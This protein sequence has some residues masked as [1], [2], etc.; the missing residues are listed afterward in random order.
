M[1]STP[2][3]PTVPPPGQLFSLAGRTALV[4][5]GSSGIGAMICAGFVAAGARVLVAARSADSLDVAVQQLSR[6]GSCE[7]VV[8][9]V[10][11]AAGCRALASEVADRCDDGLDILV[12]NAGTTSF[13]PLEH[14]SED[15][16][17]DVLSLNVTS[18]QHLTAAL[19]PQLRMRAG[20][21]SPARVLVIGSTSGFELSGLPDAVYGA[22]KAA[23]HHLARH[24]AAELVGEHILVNV[25]APGLFP[26]RL[27]AFLDDPAVR[28]PVLSTIPMGRAGR[29][30]EVA[31]AALFLCSDA[32]T[33]V[34][35]QVVVVDGGRTGLGRAD[36]VAGL[37]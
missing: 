28:E 3:I 24:W 5:G 18:V 15:D 23:V 33:Y 2:P 31:G 32:G 10:A 20:E 27:S 12:H 25:I 13:V 11:T 34:T 30:H 1:P 35:G 26:S 29:P 6:A 21:E 37:G 7:A 4:T 19:L 17:D 22:S 8:A 36:P 9:D 14:V 16:W